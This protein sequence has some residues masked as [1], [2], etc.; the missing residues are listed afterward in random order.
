MISNVIHNSSQQKRYKVLV[1]DDYESFRVVL[2]DNLR[3]KDFDVI[4]VGSARKALILLEKE[5][6]D[7]VLTDI[8]M[9]NI[10]GGKFADFVKSVDPTLQIVGMSG[11][12]SYTDDELFLHGIDHFFNKPFDMSLLSAVLR[13]LAENRSYALKNAA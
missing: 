9:P 1:I 7:V 8:L 11:G 5:N 6:I 4:D 2:C 12:C 13:E 3:D 10:D